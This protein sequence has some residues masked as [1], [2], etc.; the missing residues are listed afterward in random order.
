MTG[1]RRAI[2]RILILMIS[3][4]GLAAISS[5]AQDKVVAI[6]N[7]DIITQKDLTDFLNFMALQLSA[8]YPSWQVEERMEAA[9]ADILNRLIE[10]KLILQEAKKDNLRVD[11]NRLRAKMEQMIR[12]FPTTGDFEQSL[13]QQ[14]LTPADIESKMREQM[15]IYSIVEY[16]IKSRIVVEPAEVTDFYQKNAEEF[17]EPEGRKVSAF[18]FT[19]QPLAL[20]VLGFLSKGG[21]IQEA[22]E[23]YSLPLEDFGVIRKGQ[24]QKEIE[25]AIFNLQ[26]GET[27]GLVKVGDR[28]YILKVEEVVAAKQHAL[29]EVQDKIRSV[30]FENKMQEALVKWLDELKKKYYVEIK[31]S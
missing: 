16:K 31:Q 7:K 24:S 1:K 11:E 30:I 25:D 14:G 17:N 27:S 9:K 21:K 6:V 26:P 22:A 29:A 8:K 3:I 2:F 13:A 15:L 18:I 28:Y 12:Q 23:N 20:E 4:L 10:D 5:Y 19:E